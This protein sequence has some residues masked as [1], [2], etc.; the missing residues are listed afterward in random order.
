MPK[1][2]TALR[3]RRLPAHIVDLVESLHKF[4]SMVLRVDDNKSEAYFQAEQQVR[5]GCVLSQQLFN[6]HGEH[7]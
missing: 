4:N 5:H 1:P 3:E 6:I 7:I 2:L